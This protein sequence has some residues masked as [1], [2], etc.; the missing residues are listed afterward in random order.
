M[1]YLF[2]LNNLFK[3]NNLLKLTITRMSYNIINGKQIEILES[4][5]QKKDLY[6][7]YDNQKQNILFAE[8]NGNI[9]LHFQQIRRKPILKRRPG[10]NLI[11][12]VS[13]LG[14]RKLIDTFGEGHFDEE[15]YG[16]EISPDFFKTHIGH[17]VYNKP[18]LDEA[19]IL[20]WCYKYLASK[21]K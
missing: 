1:N 15:R 7:R 13:I 12:N 10:I 3:L 9:H 14:K 20:D 17:G 2:N 5:Y 6:F 8:P 18:I 21:K 19:E 16:Q 11:H 4:E